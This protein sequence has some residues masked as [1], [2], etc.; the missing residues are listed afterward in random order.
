MMRNYS[1][2]K[3]GIFIGYREEGY[4]RRRFRTDNRLGRSPTPREQEMSP[5]KLHI[6]LSSNDYAKHREAITKVLLSY[7]SDRNGELK[8]FKLV[9]DSIIRAESKKS[10]DLIEMLEQLQASEEA[11]SALEKKL[12]AAMTDYYE[13]PTDI[14]GRENIQDWIV[15]LNEDIKSRDRFLEGEQFIV[16]IPQDYNEAIFT[17]LCKKITRYLIKHEVTPGTH[18]DVASLLALI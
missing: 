14:P 1:Q 7:L 11:N 12:Q 8:D 3:S 5:Y 18:S 4:A 9:D 2:I 16:Y 17:N 13:E 6:S 15:S 10:L